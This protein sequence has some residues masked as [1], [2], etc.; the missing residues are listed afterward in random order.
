MRG[1]LPEVT[2]V[3][4]PMAK[5]YRQT[6]LLHGKSTYTKKDIQ[7]SNNRLYKNQLTDSGRERPGYVGKH[8]VIRSREI[9]F[10]EGEKSCCTGQISC[11]GAWPR[12]A[13]RS[14]ELR[15]CWNCNMQSFRIKSGAGHRAQGCAAGGG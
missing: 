11:S 7:N 15:V 3:G 1:I 13:G 6:G 9:L 14:V 5:V 10:T 12:R 8:A 4:Q 2:T